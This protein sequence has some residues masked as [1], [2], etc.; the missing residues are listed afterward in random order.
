MNQGQ[1]SIA[2]DSLHGQTIRSMDNQS[3]LLCCPRRSFIELIMEFWTNAETGETIWSSSGSKGNAQR[4]GMNSISFHE[5]SEISTIPAGEEFR[6]LRERSGTSQSQ[7]AARIGCSSSRVSRWESGQTDLPASSHQALQNLI[8]ELVHALSIDECQILIC[9]KCKR[10]L[11]FGEF[12]KDKRRRNGL[13]TKCRECSSTL[14]TRWRQQ[15]PNQHLLI[16]R[17]YEKKKRENLQKRKTLRRLSKGR[18]EERDRNSINQTLLGLGVVGI[19][20]Y[21]HGLIPEK[22]EEARSRGNAYLSGCHEQSLNWPGFDIA[23]IREDLSSGRISLQDVHELVKEHIHFD[24]VHL[25]VIKRESL[26][27]GAKRT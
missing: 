22:T 24:G 6:I 13:Q 27:A 5:N 7:V 16:Q 17:R 25:P 8:D 20:S 26:F 19:I 18:Y 3:H 4:I 12:A 15:N 23:A 2:I 11:R 21:N 1:L 14:A 10:E 9:W